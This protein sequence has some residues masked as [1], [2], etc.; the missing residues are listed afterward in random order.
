[1]DIN[2]LIEFSGNHSLLVMALFAILALLAADTIRRRLSGIADVEPREATRLINTENA[3]MLDMRSEEE[4][5]KGHI[6]NAIHLDTPQNI[7]S[8][9]EKL[10]GKPVIVY[11]NT[12]NRSVGVCG[13]LHKQGF[14]PVYN[15]KGGIAAW[16]K[17]ELPV[18]RKS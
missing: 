16:Q 12:G 17:A 2:Q 6:A 8:K 1:M 13:K 3:V 11:C 5:H 18:A 7:S 10:R 14:E 15:L 9:L 4:F